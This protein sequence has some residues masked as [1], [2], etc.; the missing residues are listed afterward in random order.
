L[1][2]CRGEGKTEDSELNG[3]KN[4]LN[5]ICFW[6]LWEYNFFPNALRIVFV[7][8][9]I[10]SMLQWNLLLISSHIISFIAILQAGHYIIIAT[11]ASDTHIHILWMVSSLSQVCMWWLVCYYCQPL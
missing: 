5:L 8:E 11:F 2:F 1:S 6:F 10:T 9:P 4:F 3:G 7:V